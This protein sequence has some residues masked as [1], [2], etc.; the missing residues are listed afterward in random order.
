L[1]LADWG[2]AVGGCGLRPVDYGSRMLVTFSDSFILAPGLGD[3]SMFGRVDRRHGPRNVA[4][5]L[6]DAGLKGCVVLSKG[7][8]VDDGRMNFDVSRG[9][10]RASVLMPA[11]QLCRVRCSGADDI[12]RFPK[13]YV[14][15]NG[16]YWCYAVPV[17]R[18][19][20]GLPDEEG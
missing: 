16:W 6:K 8:P 7:V 18:A 20:L 15:G 5:L 17:L 10:E 12:L 1:L 4:V 11:I 3:V 13:I 19:A 2:V 14:D 9:E